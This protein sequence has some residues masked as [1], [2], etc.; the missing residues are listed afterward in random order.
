MI[1]TIVWL[2]SIS[3]YTQ[4]SNLEEQIRRGITMVGPGIKTA[5]CGRRTFLWR[6]TGGKKWWFQ[7]QKWC[8]NQQQWWFQPTKMLISTNKNADFSKHDK[9]GGLVWLIMKNYEQ[10]DIVR[11]SDKTEI[12]PG[13]KSPN[14]ISSAWITTPLPT[15]LELGFGYVRS[16][17]SFFSSTTDSLCFLAIEQWQFSSMIYLIKMVIFHDFP[18][19]KLLNYQRVSNLYWNIGDSTFRTRKSG[20]WNATRNFDAGQTK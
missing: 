8:F 11:A 7:Q 18:L 20:D 3:Y 10:M 12:F 1:L 2:F 5:R 17:K 9:H 6:D 19:R 16:V 15:S 13:Q 14:G 4:W